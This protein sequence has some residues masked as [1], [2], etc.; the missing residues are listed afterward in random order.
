MV[1]VN[2]IAPPDDVCQVSDESALSIYE[3]G[4]KVGSRSSHS[5]VSHM[6]MTFTSVFVRFGMRLRV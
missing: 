4:P 2:P 1:A 3:R 6:D 5:L